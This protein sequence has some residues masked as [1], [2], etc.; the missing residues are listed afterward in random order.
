MLFKNCTVNGKLTDIAVKNGVIT[1]GEYDGGIIDCG[2]LTASYGFLDMHCHLRDPGYTHKEDIV[3]GLAAAAKGGFTAVMP[4]PNT[5][6]V[7]DNEKTL[8]YVLEKVEGLG[9]KV[10]PVAA[11]TVG[12]KGSELTDCAALIKAGAAAFS[13]D[14]YPVVN[15]GIA[16]EAIVNADKEGSFFISHCETP[17]LNINGKVTPE[18]EEAMI[19]RD[20]ETSLKTGARLHIAHVSTEKGVQIIREAKKN[21]AHV[22]AETC[23]HYFCF[24]E[25]EVNGNT[26]FKMNPPLRSEKDREAIIEGLKDGTLDVISTDHAPHAKEEKAREFAAAPNGILGFET[27]FSAGYTYLVK[28]GRLTLS[29]LIYKMA[30]RPYEI[31]G[32]RG[33]RFEA[34]YPADIV[35]LDLEKEFIYTEDEIRSKSKNSPFVKKKLIGRVVLTAVNGKIIYSEIN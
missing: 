26:S 20:C 6:P 10:L 28:A 5:S 21:G 11:S 34:G 30:V 22:T 17:S 32:A 24:N 12:Q 31:V 23:P 14:G 8:K 33:G 35:L 18:S 9:V 16:R 29:E 2:G 15:D 4:M 3:T 7:T 25:T 27:A 19:A 13:D 1:D